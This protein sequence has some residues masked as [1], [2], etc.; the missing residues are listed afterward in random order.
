MPSQSLAIPLQ[1]GCNGCCFEIGFYLSRE[2]G[3]IQ[4]GEGIVIGCKACGMERT[5]LVGVGM[6]YSSLETIMPL[7]QPKDRTQIQ[8]IFDNHSVSLREWSHGIFV[9]AVCNRLYNRFYAKITYD[10]DMVY[11][12][13]FSCSKCEPRLTLL[14][15]LGEIKHL[16]C[17]KCGK[18]SLEFREDYLWD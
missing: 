9:C 16:P 6:K 8:Q 14:N 1:E 4:M 18:R 7:L 5:F 15:D 2:C 13:A 17:P 11:E 3:G 12:T 10:H